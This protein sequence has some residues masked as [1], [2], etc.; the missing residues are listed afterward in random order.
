M[1]IKTKVF[2]VV[3]LLIIGGSV[4]SLLTRLY[5]PTLLGA[6]NPKNFSTS[7]YFTT[8]TDHELLPGNSSPIRVDQYGQTILA[9]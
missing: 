3:M 7:V 9:N 8:T 1:N 5:T 4:G 2:W 6:Y